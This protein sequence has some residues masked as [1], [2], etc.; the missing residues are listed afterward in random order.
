MRSLLPNQHLIDLVLTKMS[1]N[2]PPCCQ[3]EL[4]S[5][6]ATVKSSSS[7]PESSC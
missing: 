1:S 5:T 4:K 2:L 3:T 6:L 7:V